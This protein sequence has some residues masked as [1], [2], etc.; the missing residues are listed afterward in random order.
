MFRSKGFSLIYKKLSRQSRNKMM[1]FYKESSKLHQKDANFPHRYLLFI[2]VDPEHQ[3][4]GY[5]GALLKPMLN[6]F[7]EEKL[8]V[9]LETQNADNVTFYEH[10]NFKVIEK[11]NISGTEFTHYAMSKSP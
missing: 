6:R 1:D 5:A 11:T 9:Y 10:F 8:A 7:E 2:G 3:V 4:K